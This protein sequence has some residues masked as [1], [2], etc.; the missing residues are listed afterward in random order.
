MINVLTN[1]AIQIF[2]PSSVTI[3]TR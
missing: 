1:G 2:I 3:R